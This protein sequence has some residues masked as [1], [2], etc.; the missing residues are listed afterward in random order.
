MTNLLKTYDIHNVRDNGLLKLFSKR[1]L[2][3][4][5]TRKL[6]HMS[7]VLPVSPFIRMFLQWP[8]DT[9]L[10]IKDLRLKALTLFISLN[11]AVEAS[12]CVSECGMAQCRESVRKNVLQH[13]LCDI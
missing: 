12:R 8:D 11:L 9:E 4:S 6:W 2:I 7:Q 3:M 5:V 1:L 13:R 10:P